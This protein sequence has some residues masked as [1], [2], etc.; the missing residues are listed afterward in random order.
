MQELSFEL[1]PLWLSDQGLLQLHHLG[2][3]LKGRYRFC[4]SPARPG[5]L[6]PICI[7]NT[8]PQGIFIHTESQK[9]ALRGGLAVK[10]NVFVKLPYH[11]NYYILIH[12]TSIC[13]TEG[14]TPNE[15]GVGLSFSGT[16]TYTCYFCDRS[17]YWHF[18]I[19][20][21][22]LLWN[23]CYKFHL[24]K[25][26]GVLH[27]WRLWIISNFSFLKSIISEKAFF[28]HAPPPQKVSYSYTI[29]RLKFLPWEENTLWLKIFT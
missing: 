26:E 23:L 22:T 21:H 1:R 15:T 14:T 2:R 24:L 16:S 4:S 20:L 29:F 9:R 18:G 28:S 17:S 12:S 11:L 25:T 3:L 13:W 10:R 8:F 5:N 27:M 7:F 19:G 6:E